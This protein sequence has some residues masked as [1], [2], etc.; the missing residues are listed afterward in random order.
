MARF[1]VWLS[2]GLILVFLLI[3]VAFPQSAPGAGIQPFSTQIGGQYDSIDLAASNILIQI[4][5]R[6]KTGKIPF[7][8]QLVSNTNAS[9]LLNADNNLVWHVGF[10]FPGSASAADLGVTARGTLIKFSGTYCNGIGGQIVTE[11]AYW[12]AFDALGTSHP[13]PTTFVVNMCPGVTLPGLAVTTDGSGYTLEVTSNNPLTYVVYDSSGNKASPS[14]TSLAATV[15][16]PDNA[17]VSFDGSIYTDTLGATA[18]TVQM[19]YGPSPDTYTYTD[20]S[21]STPRTFTVAYSPYNIQT[22]FRCSG[23]LEWSLPSW[24]LPTSITTPTGG[25][26]TISYEQ[27]PEYGTAYKT[28]RIAQITLPTGGYV[29]YVYSGGSNNTGIDCTSQVVPTLTRTVNDNNGNVSTWTYVNTDSNAPSACAP[30]GGSCNYTV[31]ETDPAANQTVYYFSGEYQTAVWSY[32]GQ[33]TGGYTGALRVTT[34]CYNGNFTNCQYSA[35][36]SLPIKQTDVYTWLGAVPQALTETI[37]DCATISPCYGNVGEIKRYDWGAGSPPSGSPL[38]DEI[39]RYGSYN[40]GPCNALPNNIQNGVCADQVTGAVLTSLATYSYTGNHPTTIN[41]WVS[42]QSNYLTDNLVWNPNGTLQSAQDA[43]GNMTKFFY[44][45][46]GGCQ[47]FLLTSTTYA[48]SSVGSDSQTW[49]CNGGVKTKYTDVNNNSTTYSYTANGD[50]PLYRIKSI[51]NPDG[52]VV[53]YSYSTGSS[54]PWSVASSTNIGVN[55]STITSTTVLDGLGR[56][57]LASGNTYSSF[58]DPNAGGG[59][60]YDGVQYNNLGQ[61]AAS[62]TPYFTSTDQTYGSTTFT[63]DALGRV[64]NEALPSN[65]NIVTAYTG[66]ATTV[67]QFPNYQNYQTISQ[68]DGLGRIVDVC[69][70]TA[71]N[72][73]NGDAP[74]GCG[75]DAPGTGFNT[76]NTYD[77]LGNLLSSTVGSN[78]ANPETASFSYDGLSRATAVKTEDGETIIYAYDTGSAGD[79]YTRTTPLENQTGSATVVATYSWDQMHRPLQVNYNDGITPTITHVYD[80]SSWW[81]TTLTN[82]KG[83]LTST[84]T[85]AANVNGNGTDAIYGYD[86]MGRASVYGQCA[87]AGCLASTPVRFI[88]NYTY[89]YAGL[90]IT[91]MDNIVGNVTM[92]PAYNSIGQLNGLGTNCL[93][94]NRS[95]CVAGNVFTGATYNALGRPVS[96][97]LGIGSGLTEAWSYGLNAAI[98]G[99]DSYSAGS[100]YSWS[101]THNQPLVITNSTDTVNGNWNYTY[102]SFNRLTCAWVGSACNSSAT[103]AVS[104]TYDQFDNR[105]KQTMLAG[106]GYNVNNSYNGFNH[107]TTAGYTY[108]K[109]GNVTYDTFHTYTY[110]AEGRLLTVDGGVGNGGETYNYNSRGLRNLTHQGVWEEVLYNVDGS[111]EAT[112]LPGTNTLAWSE[113]YGYRHIGTFT[114]GGLNTTIYLLPDWLGTNRYWMEQSGSYFTSS[115]TLPY[116]EILSPGIGD[117][118]TGISGLFLDYADNT[119]HTDARQLSLNAGR[120]LTPDPAIML[121]NRYAYVMNNPVSYTDPSGLRCYAQEIWHHLCGQLGDQGQFGWNWDEFGLLNFYW[122]YE[123]SDEHVYWFPALGLVN[124]FSGGQPDINKTWP[125]TFPCNKNAKQLMSAVQHNMGQFAD[126]RGTLFAANFPDQPL[127]LGSQY[128]IQPGLNSHDPSNYEL[129]MGNLVVTV[130]SQTANGWTFTTDPSQHY[131]D[132][133]VSFSSTDA[134]NGNVTFSVTAN[135]NYSSRFSSFFG[136]IIQAG[137]NSTWNNL[138]N[139]VQKYCRSNFGVR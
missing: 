36:P 52:G 6:S 119:V 56:A 100:A 47:D 17:H 109:A 44:N 138:L 113:F 129:P 1:A 93:T 20:A 76:A 11:Y 8:Y 34:T 46:T 118:W 71:T 90:P 126:N 15:A 84:A 133:T 19:N 23:I 16:D 116:G 130:T 124:L 7:V 42:G 77:A 55:E 35:V 91:G 59:L 115:A 120:W 132:G 69:K 63:Y 81:S 127:T 139:N 72:Q 40:G 108:D 32:Q 98:T 122:P 97:T 24:Y 50:D 83:H 9:T 58:T 51:T 64:T 31:T 43:G 54:L 37:Y 104:W 48:M 123:G 94:I 85:S 5:I 117:G 121:G 30:G 106:T 87:I 18:L 62:Y 105:Y 25:K 80:Q 27:T 82:P 2:L 92:S 125:G 110:D 136:P 86:S 70:L 88:K 41:H 101:V 111:Q 57:V 21:G 78:A 103:T 107:I 49:D 10:G 68:I 99:A 4:P 39:I 45:G 38:S 95:S 66:R 112:V 26:Y 13:L 89:N 75:L 29:K 131:F 33:S 79:L 114:A 3:G 22:N 14:A 61:V 28:G 102:D 134:G 128:L 135:A 53:N 73:A 67:T 12:Y 60:K 65:Q 96:S 74:K 137:E